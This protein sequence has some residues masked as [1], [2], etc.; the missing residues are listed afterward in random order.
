MDAKKIIR[1][2]KGNWLGSYGTARCP[3]HNDA[4]PSLS[5]CNQNG[6]I[7]VKCHAGCSQDAVISALKTIG[8]WDD[9]AQEMVRPDKKPYDKSA[10]VSKLWRSSKPILHTNAHDYLN[11]RSISIYPASLRYHP[12]IFHSPS[13]QK[14]EAI[15]AGITRWPS[16]CPHAVHRTYLSNGGKANI[17]PNKMMLGRINGGAVRMGSADHIIALAEGIETALSV[18]QLTNIPTWAV[19]SSSNYNGLILPEN[20]QEIHIF[21]DH[22]KAGL[23]KA[24][25]AA[26]KWTKAGI[27]VFVKF[28]KIKGQDFND[29]INQGVL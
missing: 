29:L 19:L 9:N 12:Q 27:R 17:E 4:K 28:P 6:K 23:S 14:Y 1:A 13:K 24:Q 15:I 22:D 18:Q 10:Y 11:S 20:V 25:E 26:T 5:I 8:L 7:L 2:L 21:A 3:A 16:K